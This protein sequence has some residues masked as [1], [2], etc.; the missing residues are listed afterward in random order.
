M[1]PAE[2]IFNAVRFAYHP[3]GWSLCVPKLRMGQERVTCIIGPNGSGK[4]TLLRL[5]AGILTP[6]EGSVRLGSEDIGAIP[7]R[8]LARRIGFLPQEAPPLFDVSVDTLTRMGRYS[9]TGWIGTMTENDHRAVNEALAQT[10]MQQLRGRPLSHLSGGERRRAL[11][12]SVLA[13]EPSVLL[14]D[15]PTAA[16]DLHHAA[17]VIR[18]LARS[19][20]PGRSV[21]IVTHDINLAALYADRLILV[22]AGRIAADGP[23]ADVITDAIIREAYGED[24]I[25]APH[26]ES[27]APM[28]IARSGGHARNN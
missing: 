13:Q 23:P 20:P 22:V 4:S 9:H 28:A 25:V 14:L 11:I 19:G 10:N 3:D 6:H 7:R 5:A 27:G 1:N 24:I 21:I 2:I 16:L 18:L 17:R 15:E 26:P 12:A 8:M